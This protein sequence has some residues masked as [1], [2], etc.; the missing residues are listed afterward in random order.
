MIDFVEVGNMIQN[1]RREMKLSQDEL[2]SKLYITRQ[3]LSKW[4]NGTSIPSIDSLFELC[5]I[6]SKSFEEILCLNH[7]SPIDPDNIFNGHERNFVIEQIISNKINVDVS[8]VLYQM[9]P[10]E[11][12]AIIKAVKEGKI[13]V[14]MEEFLV[15][16]T[17]A[18]KR[19]L[20]GGNYYEIKKSD[21]RW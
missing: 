2:A 5:K 3:A 21:C 12:L 14:D 18:E 16:L 11:R 1:K 9:S 17:K 15:K 10:S 6:F 8:D 13:K 7:S 4:E 20:L 19:Y